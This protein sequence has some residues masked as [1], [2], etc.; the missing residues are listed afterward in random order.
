MSVKDIEYGIG[1]GIP[2]STLFEKID[3]RDNNE[4]SIALKC[5]EIVASASSEKQ[6]QLLEIIQRIEEYWKSK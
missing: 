2:I 1:L 5:Y 6:E 4:S 3:D